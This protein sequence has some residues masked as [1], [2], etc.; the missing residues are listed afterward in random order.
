MSGGDPVPEEEGSA[1]AGIA[2]AVAP[3][4]PLTGYYR[5]AEERPA[6]VRA[7]F[8]RTA[9]HYD[10]I[11]A[12]MSLG[13]GR[14]YRREML[15]SAGLR[16]GMAVLDVAVGTGQVAGEARRLLAGRGT[17]VGL[18]ASE[19][20]LARAR[21]AGAADALV[22]GRADALP[23]ADGSF[24]LV[25]MGY[26]LRHVA[27]LA[28]AFG[29]LGRVLAPGGTLLVLE[30]TPP[31]HRPGRALL[32]VYLGRVL[33]LVS[34]LT[35]GSHDARTLMRYHWD[36]V[37]ACV[38]P[39]TILAAMRGADLTH[40]RCDVQFGFLRAYV[41]RKTQRRRRDSDQVPRADDGAMPD[42]DHGH[43]KQG[44]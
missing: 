20:M 5:S 36:T 10:R 21:N 40:S 44:R 24:D 12:L 32:R 37:E 7:L 17:V 13:W 9:R 8:D 15:R 14:R 3:H 16:P 1:G 35:T 38:P 34:L 22:L 23:F 29:E 31:R 33:P 30:L 25:S 19:G 4:P 18:D 26:A 6:Y 11:N 41:G 43:Q 2:A 28:L 27:D 42:G 39:E